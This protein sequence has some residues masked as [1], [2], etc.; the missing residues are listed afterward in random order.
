[1]SLITYKSSAGSGKTSTLVIEYLAIALQKP[2]QFRQIIA[3]TFTQK[4]TAEMK[5]RL[6]DSLVS[7]KNMDETNPDSSIDY[8]IAAIAKKTGFNNQEIKF[9]SDLLLRNILHNY[10]DFGFSTIDS[11]VV[12]IVKSFA[13]DLQLSA[14]FEIELD[15]N[16]LI[17][18]AIE[19]L[20]EL[21]GRNKEITSFMLDYANEKLDD[22]KS[23]DLDDPLSNLGRL[24]F[25]SKHYKS[26]DSI[27]D[28]KLESFVEIK[29][30][31]Q[32]KINTII[33]TVKDF[34]NQGL[35]CIN[36]NG[37]RKGD[38][39]S[40]W[41]WSYFNKLQTTP[42]SIYD[43]DKLE[44]ATFIKKVDN[45]DEWYTKKQTPDIIAKI[46]TAQANI[47]EIISKAREYY[48]TEAS[49]LI[50]YNMI[51]SKITPLALIHQ[52]KQIIEENYEANDV[53]HLSEV[54]RKISEVV[55]EQ[56]APFI[57]ERIGQRYNHFL[58]DE[59]QDTSV[60]QW[61]NML[62]LIDNSLASNNRN[63]LVGDTKQSIY[64]WRDGEVEQFA[65]LPNLLGENKSL[66]RQQ[67]E[68]LLKSMYK[69][70]VLDYNYRSSENIVNFNNTFFT[71][72]LDTESDYVKEH[73][74]DHEQKTYKTKNVGIIKL[75]NIPENKESDSKN[76]DLLKQIKENIDELVSDQ[77]YKYGDIC[78]LARKNK[79]LSELATYLI[80]NGIKVVSADALYL[81]SSKSVN[82]IINFM[83]IMVEQNMGINSYALLRHF[84]ENHNLGE[85]SIVFT[86][87]VELLQH[88]NSL[89]YTFDN[90]L[91]QNMDS[92]ELSEY[93]IDNINFKNTSNPFIFYLLDKIIEQ[94]KQ[95]GASISQFLEYWEEKKDNLKIDLAADENSV[96]LLS[97][98]KSKGLE[99]PVVIFPL[100]Q[101]DAKLS[102]RDMLWAEPDEEFRKKMPQVLIGDE[103]RG[104]KSYFKEVLSQELDRKQLDAMNMIYVAN[105]RPTEQLHILFNSSSDSKK[106]WETCQSLNWDDTREVIK[107]DNFIQI[108]NNID[109]KKSKAAP[110]PIQINSFI[111][112]YW[113]HKI[114]LQSDINTNQKLRDKGTQ[115]HNLLANINDTTN[116]DEIISS[117]E[118][119]QF[120]SKEYS[121]EFKEIIT[122]LLKNEDTKEFFNSKNIIL[123]EKEILTASGKALRP[124]KIVETKKEILVI[125][126]K[127]TNEET[128]SKEEVEKYKSQINNYK[129]VLSNIYN[130][131][132]KGYLLFLKP[133]KSLIVE[134]QTS[135]FY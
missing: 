10:G 45:G 17:T 80:E 27:K 40:K 102:G 50:S 126:Y 73:F 125:D 132:I 34:G 103:Q 57:Y 70:V 95:N 52:L 67:Q 121:E 64:R 99:F 18:E 108:G 66:I 2:S 53:I 11:F 55:N 100:I 92:Y 12:R 88:I 16:K 97:I 114:S 6:I 37:L 119:R 110:K 41:L 3:L 130:Q 30:E 43:I 38:C 31:L 75:Q 129:S 77:E 29:K 58:I 82:L 106:Y 48:N 133:I 112:N 47:R 123:N 98:H 87:K 7:L 71:Q 124:D 79:F 90:L 76:E 26:I 105:T 93:V 15:S 115:L 42:E 91:M 94:S 127:Y 25:D 134:Q 117:F 44:N 116:I 89:G 65:K 85:P 49:K 33:K 19:Q 68:N 101:I 62:P 74:Q 32:T 72:L 113:R 46:E 104:L 107:D 69:E 63:L 135:L 122:E 78:I 35:D 131:N 21:I 20:N 60:I 51:L 96:Q 14:N 118:K 109:R 8:V 56:H 23:P 28:V 5:E 84:Y 39:S 36:N 1:M 61:N 128:L 54:N 86:N 13:H 120:I 83:K 111:S 81:K 59:F 22:E 4:A 24:I 9:K